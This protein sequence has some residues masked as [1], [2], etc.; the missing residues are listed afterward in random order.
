MSFAFHI[1]APPSHLFSFVVSFII[2]KSSYKK[3]QELVNKSNYLHFSATTIWITIISSLDCCD[4]FLILS[5]AW[6]FLDNLLLSWLSYPF[7]YTFSLIKGPPA[8]YS[9]GTLPLFSITKKISL[10]FTLL[11]S[12]HLKHLPS[13]RILSHLPSSIIPI[14]LC[15]IFSHYSQWLQIMRL[16]NSL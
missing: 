12:F 11:K 13:S 3:C 1:S 16:K 9:S 10:Q 7:P 4:H 5:Q 14:L 8:S 2:Y 15:P 6:L